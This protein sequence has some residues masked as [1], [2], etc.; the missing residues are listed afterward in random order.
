MS[1]AETSLEDGNNNI[2]NSDEFEDYGPYDIRNVGIRTIPSDYNIKT[3]VDT[4]KDGIIV[5]PG[6][7]R[8][9][10]WTKKQAS[11]LIESLILGLPVPQIFFYETVD[12]NL[13]VI[14]GQQRLMSI[15]Y[16]VYQRFP[17]DYIRTIPDTHRKVGN[18]PLD[19]D[20]YFA[21][22]KL[23]LPSL[24][25]DEKNPLH[26]L[27]YSKLPDDIKARFD[28]RPIRTITVSQTKDDKSAMYE[29]FNRLNSGVTLNPQEI[30]RSMF[31]SKFYEMIYEL[32]AN[33]HWRKLYGSTIPDPHMRDAEMLLRGFAMLE[34]GSNYK[35]SMVKF[36]N[37]Y[38]DDAKKYDNTHIQKLKTLAVS[39]F[40]NNRHIQ[41][42]AS[43]SKKPSPNIFDCVFVAS[44]HQAHSQGGTNARAINSSSLAKLKENPDFKETTQMQTSSIANVA[45]R[46]NLSRNMLSE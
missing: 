32:N 38:S 36:L 27:S 15:Y 18:L 2:D 33:S 30:R 5:I 6:F 23:Q 44:C 9:Y 46:L 19:N 25:H 14:D 31:D 8:N 37:Q 10:V 35:P 28:R 45:K 13:L 26:G 17:K 29:V 7:Q 20:E 42:N 16:F 4:I 40:E 22:F 11:K 43:D 34:Q 3:L 21:D 39:F 24:T 41:L 12:D 1:P